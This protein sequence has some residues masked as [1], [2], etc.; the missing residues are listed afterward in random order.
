M[1][2]IKHYHGITNHRTPIENPVSRWAGANKVTFKQ[3]AEFIND[4]DPFNDK[5]VNVKITDDDV[6]FIIT[7][8][9]K[10]PNLYS[11]RGYDC[12]PFKT[13]N[14]L[15]TLIYEIDRHNHKFD[16]K[17]RSRGKRVD[18]SYENWA[19]KDYAHIIYWKLTIAKDDLLETFHR[20][21]ELK[22]RDHTVMT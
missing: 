19:G 14:Y 9:D 18:W 1:I 16:H 6:T 10:C 11:H 12:S 15:I 4:K 7:V 22:G 13:D 2:K 3:L 5:S 21:P 17:K 8:D 20:Y